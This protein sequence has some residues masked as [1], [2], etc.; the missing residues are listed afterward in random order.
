MVRIAVRSFIVALFVAFA[1]SQVVMAQEWKNIVPLVSTC[2]D[3]KKLLNVA[4]CAHPWMKYETP[5]YDIYVDFITDKN[6]WNVSDDTVEGVHVVFHELVRLGDFE[7]DLKDYSIRREDDVPEISI[8]KNDKK[9][10]SLSVQTGIAEGSYISSIFIY[11]SQD[12]RN[13]FKCKPSH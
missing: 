10:I 12:N 4:E 1:G 9:G 6:K 7:T 5:K 11:P 3:V 8:Y 2:S 13:R